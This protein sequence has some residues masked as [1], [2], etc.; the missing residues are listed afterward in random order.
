LVFQQAGAALMLHGAISNNPR[1]PS[2]AAQRQTE[3]KFCL[4]SDTGAELRNK[5]IPNAF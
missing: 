2:I 1:P 5:L 3:Q 4:E